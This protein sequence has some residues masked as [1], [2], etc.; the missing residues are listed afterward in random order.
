M[1]LRDLVPIVVALIG[2]AGVIVQVRG[3]RRALPEHWLHK[4]EGAQKHPAA[5]RRG[6]FGGAFLAPSLPVLLLGVAL[7]VVGSGVAVR[8]V[9]R[10]AK[11]TVGITEPAEG[12]TEPMDA[13][14]RGTAAGLGRGDSLWV[15]VYVPGLRR[16][17][18][19][20]APVADAADGGWS[21]GARLGEAPDKGKAFELLA[22]TADRRAREA[23]RAYFATPPANGV[24]TGMEQLPR[25][26][27]EVDR[28]R[29][30]RDAAPAAQVYSPTRQRYAREE[31]PLG[32][33]LIGIYD[34]ANNR[35]R[36]VDVVQHP[37]D[38]SPN[39][40]RAIAWSP[41]EKLLA[42]MF[43][44]APGGHV[45]I[46]DAE[47]G[48]ELGYVKLGTPYRTLEFSP[49]EQSILVDGIPIQISSKLQRW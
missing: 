6:G 5:A 7:L 27:E 25:G 16:Y 2:L 30:V 20:D 36:S 1:E 18:P 45:S 46:V 12:A 48:V 23:F 33:G 42:V 13:T 40:V 32:Q 49:D 28:V 15:V 3:R 19:Q 8:N 10:P 31:E 24:W 21:A 47:R 22:V 44:H 34:A 37:R 4:E 11:P 14:L 17:F 39:A 26:A 29:V 41:D 9:V 38:D 35:L 43:H